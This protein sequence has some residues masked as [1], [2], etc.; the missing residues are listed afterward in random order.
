MSLE[1][2][3]SVAQILPNDSKAILVEKLVASIEADIDPQVTKS[4][5]AEV[6][7]RRDEIR[8]EK[9]AP[10]NGEEGLANVRAMIGK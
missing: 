6:K 4:H 10:I 1:E 2:I 8:S 7:K 5:L 3:F 9:V